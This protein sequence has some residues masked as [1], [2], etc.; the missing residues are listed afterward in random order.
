MSQPANQAVCPG[1]A[2]AAVNF[3]GGVTGT[4]YNW[5]NNNTSI[6]L[7]ASGTG[8]IPSFTSVNNSTSTVTATITVSQS[9]N[10]CNS[11]LQ[12]TFTI[13]VNPSTQVIQ[14][15]NQTV[16]PGTAT[17]PVNFSGGVTGT[18]YSW[19]NNN[20]SI[21]LAAS[22]NGN[23]GSI[24]AVNNTTSPETATITVTPITYLPSAVGC[25]GTAQS[26]TIIVTPPNTQVTQPASQTVCSGQA[27]TAVNFSGGAA[28]TVYNW[29]AVMSPQFIDQSNSSVG[30]GTGACTKIWQSF[31]AG[32]SGNLSQVAMEIDNSTASGTLSIYS[33][34]GTGGALLY[35]TPFSVSTSAWGNL[36][37]FP[38][39]F[40]PITSGQQYTMSFVCSSGTIWSG[41]NN[42]VYPGGSLYTTNIGQ[43]VQGAAVVFQTYVSPTIGLAA[44]GTG[45]IPSFTAVNKTS[46]PVTATVTVTPSLNGCNGTLQTFTIA[47][48][49]PPVAA[50]TSAPTSICSGSTMISGTITATGAWTLA[51]NDGTTTVTGTGS[52][53][54]SASVSPTSNKTY[55]ISTLTDASC[56]AISTGLTGSESV[57]VN[58][59][60]VAAI[61]SAPTSICSGASTTISGTITATAAWTLTLI[62]GTTATGTGS[63]TWSANVT[64]ST[65]TNYTISSLNDANCTANFSGLTGSVTINVNPI[66]SISSISGVINISQGSSTTLTAISAATNPTYNWYSSATGGR[67]YILVYPLQLLH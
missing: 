23:I 12:K 31:T 65:N 54:W 63:G 22:G 25:S 18:T 17:A 27:T 8:N 38:T 37:Y 61:T 60:P 24:T 4:T 1:T 64:P 2:T 57:T 29:S 66:P 3:S 41:Y 34:S 56:S 50:I 7:G 55:T 43:A 51:L 9:A 42:P 59:L 44:S 36:S 13:A 48:N 58:A 15:A 32:I 5:T 28:G 47:A 53:T 19:T 6:G 39:N 11:T 40:I 67:C 49:V 35:S 62:D 20:T 21:G 26:F 16:C 52:G 33:G 14:P 10:A 46:S 45:D 30:V